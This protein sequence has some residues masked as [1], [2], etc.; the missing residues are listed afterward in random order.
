MIA[1]FK[2][3]MPQG[4]ESELMNI[5]NSGQLA[6]GKYGREFEDKL[7]AFLGNSLT[8]TASSFNQALLMALST[9]DLKPGDEIIAS[10]VSCLA[11]NQPFAIKGLSIKWIDVDPSTS[12]MDVS[13]LRGMITPKTK[14]IFNNIFC[15]FA[16]DLNEVYEIGKEFGI[17]VVDDCI[18]GFG[19]KYKGKYTGNT[20][21][22]ITVF[23][24]QTVRLPNTVDGG[25]L[26]FKDDSLYQKAKLIRDYGIDR[27]HFR[28]KNGEINPDC[29]IKLEG[30]GA[31]MSEINSYIGVQQ[32][33]DLNGLFSIQKKNAQKWN[34]FFKDFND[35]KPLS[36][37]KDCQPNYWVYGVLADNKLDFIQKMKD[38]GFYATG[39]HINNNI[40]S[41]FGN[42]VDLPGV[43]EFMKKYVALPS[44][45]WFTK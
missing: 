1:I 29:D 44:G 5:L 13:K 17:P 37:E 40:Y 34:L 23:S 25:A 27:T 22:D 11:S 15:G 2:P 35:A 36:I 18:E 6:Y 26:T 32:M 9:L 33:N 43:N 7:G 45:W 28:L 39:V 16:G 30:Y 21:A 3:Y 14:A 4:I 24:F 42:K 8:L 31:T 12:T 41:V 10:P 38:Q 19:T 20:G